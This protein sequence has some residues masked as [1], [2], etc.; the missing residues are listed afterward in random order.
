MDVCCASVGTSVCGNSGAVVSGRSHSCFGASDAN[1]GSGNQLIRANPVP[2]P[3]GCPCKIPCACPCACPCPMNLQDYSD[4]KRPRWAKNLVSRMFFWARARARTR[5]RKIGY[6]RSLIRP[7]WAKN[8]VSRMFFF[9]HAHG[10]WGWA[11]DL[12][13]LRLFFTKIKFAQG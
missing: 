7:R 2:I 1:G 10:Q 6:A 5:A 13:R 12:H 11:W 3:C 9:G 8:L 4:S